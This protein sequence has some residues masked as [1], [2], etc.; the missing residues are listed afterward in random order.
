MGVFLKAFGFVSSYKYIHIPLSSL[1]KVLRR[2]IMALSIFEQVRHMV[3]PPPTPTPSTN[4]T[5]K[6][7]GP[8]GRPNWPDASAL[9]PKD[10]AMP[11]RSPTPPP[12]GRAFP[13]RYGMCPGLEQSGKVLADFCK[14]ELYTFR[15]ILVAREAAGGGQGVGASPRASLQ[16]VKRLYAQRR[17]ASSEE[18]GLSAHPTAS[19]SMTKLQVTHKASPPQNLRL[20]KPFQPL[21]SS[22]C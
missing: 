11:G 18:A 15:Q 13:F 6:A 10:S 1:K 5:L 7:A 4:V 16:T 12:K 9:R 20:V 21:S 22:P 3:Q 19:R 14:R 8:Y 17:Q 2:L